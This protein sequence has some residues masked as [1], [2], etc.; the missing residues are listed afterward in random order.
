MLIS[1]MAIYAFLR[2]ILIPLTIISQLV[3]WRPL[4]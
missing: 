3:G 4:L 2:F 1:L